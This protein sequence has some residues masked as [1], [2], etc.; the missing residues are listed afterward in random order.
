MLPEYSRIIDRRKIFIFGLP[1]VLVVYKTA[2]T[3]SFK[4]LKHYIYSYHPTD[5]FRVYTTDTT[6]NTPYQY[7]SLIDMTQMIL[8]L[9]TQVIETS[10]VV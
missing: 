9:F 4:I 8:Y 5:I 3:I 1:K 10:G 7:Q 2:Y 6:A